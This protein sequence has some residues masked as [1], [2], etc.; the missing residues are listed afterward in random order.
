MPY[1]EVRNMNAAKGYESDNEYYNTKSPN[2]VPLLLNKNNISYW[3]S[4]RITLMLSIL[5]SSFSLTAQQPLI[6][7]D[8]L[9]LSQIIIPIQINLKP[10][11]A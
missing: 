11:Y 10:V 9:P 7:I 1:N 8:S 5:F 4:I 6:N 3:L 2:Q